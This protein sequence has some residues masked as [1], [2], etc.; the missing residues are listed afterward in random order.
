M[1]EKKNLPKLRER[2]LR[3]WN[4]FSKN[5]LAFTKDSSPIEFLSQEKSLNKRKK[6]RIKTFGNQE[7]ILIER[8]VSRGDQKDQQKSFLW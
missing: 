6:R 1:N 7:T 4:P 8:E 5:W 3:F 2:N